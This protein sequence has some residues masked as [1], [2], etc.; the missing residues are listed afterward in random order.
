M[1][2]NTSV[3]PSRFRWVDAIRA[4]GAFLVVLAHVQYS[5]AGPSVIRD[6][7]YALTRAAVPMFFM[8]SGF[9]LLSKSEPYSDFFRKRA[10]KVFIPFLVWSVIYLLW[11]KESFDD[12]PLIIVKT[13]LLKIVR[14]PRENHLW[15]FYELFGLYLF[16]PILRVYLQKAD[17][18][19]LYYFCGAW[20]LL[21]PVAKAI[22]DFTPI[23][24][25]FTYYF[26]SG[27]IGYFLFG[28]LAGT[29]EL[30]DNHRHIAW[31]VFLEGALLTVA[32]MSMSGYYGI[33][34]QYFEDYLSVNV[35]VMSCA[36]F[37]ALIGQPVSDSACRFVTPLS[38]ASFG[39]YLAHVIVM[40]QFFAI[41]PFSILPEIGSNVYMIPVIGLL[42]FGLTFFLIFILQKIP[43]LKKIVP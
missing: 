22:Q 42:G 30:N 3:A 32:G 2:T 11:K 40:T 37:V 27:Y 29:M 20:F 26:L 10:V 39:I 8:A 33:K 9:L 35:V 25:G 7:Y 17:R 36:L 14:G 5:G 18:K 24:I 19:D 38:R 23:Q 28:Y 13:Y 34:N 16:T 31:I 15:F 41:P 12:S 6:L 4:L 43:F 21:I 1:Q